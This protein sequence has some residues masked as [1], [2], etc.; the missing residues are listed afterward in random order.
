M[1]LFSFVG[2]FS[3][4]VYLSASF[5]H[6]HIFVVCWV[7]WG[8]WYFPS[9][10]VW[11]ISI[12]IVLVWVA[13]FWRCLPSLEYVLTRCQ[14]DR[15]IH[16]KNSTARWP[17]FL[18]CSVHLNIFKTRQLT[19][20]QSRWITALQVRGK[21]H[22][23]HFEEDWTLIGFVSV[24]HILMNQHIQYCMIYRAWYNRCQWNGG[25]SG[26]RVIFWN[27]PYF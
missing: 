9:H 18:N 14:S 4:L 11:Y 20:K 6:S 16:L 26:I 13:K 27:P 10:L 21:I 19:L 12:K 8:F 22:I 24:W 2:L 25:I 7:G 1:T 15:I 17:F 3:F 5:S 23:F